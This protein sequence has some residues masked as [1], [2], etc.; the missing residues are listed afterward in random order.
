MNFLYHYTS[1]ETLAL[2]LKDQKI[3]LN[4]LINVDDPEEAKSRDIKNIGRLCVVSC[5]TDIEQDSLPMWNMYTSDMKGVRIKMKTYPFK[6]Y[7]P[8]LDFPVKFSESYVDERKVL[9]DDIAMIIPPSLVLEKVEYTEDE[10]KLFPK[11]MD[12]EDQSYNTDY[13]GKYKRTCWSFQSE[14]RYKI[15]FTPFSRSEIVNNEAAFDKMHR[16]WK[17]PY[18]EFYLDLAEDAFEGSE[19]ILG[20][21]TSEAQKIIVE[22]LVDKYQQKYH[23][24]IKKSKIH[25]R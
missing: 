18:R 4:C 20:P 6:T 2:I 24:H 5:W 22:A 9:E 8:V 19:I 14:W 21:K 13:I 23:I 3:R 15:L 1:I 12:D 25:V 16:G 10:E 17:V 7:M 11:I